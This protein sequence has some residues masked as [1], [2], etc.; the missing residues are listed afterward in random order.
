VLSSHFST[1]C[2]KWSW[3]CSAPPSTPLATALFQALYNIGSHLPFLPFTPDHF[4]LVVVW[5]QAFISTLT[6]SEIFSGECGA[7]I[8]MT[9]NHRRIYHWATWVMPPL[10]CE[11]SAYG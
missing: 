11:K 3:G 6:V 8:D 9:L 5:N 10:N 7:M 1:G 4:L 2:V